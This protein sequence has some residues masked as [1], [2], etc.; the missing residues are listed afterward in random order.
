MASEI[1]LVTTGSGNGMSP[2]WIKILNFIEEMHLKM[3]S[4]T[5][6]PFSWCLDGLTHW[7]EWCLYVS[8]NKPSLVQ[9]MACHLVGAKL[10]T[11]PMLLYCLFQPWW[12]LKWNSSI[13]IK[14]NTFE[15]IVCE[16]APIL[17]RLQCVNRFI[18]V[19]LKT[20]RTQPSSCIWP[21]WCCRRQI[22][23]MW[24][25]MYGVGKRSNPRQSV[26][27]K[28]CPS[29]TMQHSWRSYWRYVALS[30]SCG[31]IESLI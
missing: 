24:P 19:P 18:T 8:V 17:F 27:W 5:C 21:T 22:P 31:A 7:A 1:F 29:M 15:N 3:S 2:I 9:I 11:E 13:F 25:V 20:A 6:W 28:S 23:A 16:M 26:S 4:A 10:L 12:N 14:E 30:I